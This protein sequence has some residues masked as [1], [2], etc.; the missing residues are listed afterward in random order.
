MD[1]VSSRWEKYTE[2]GGGKRVDILGALMD[3]KDP[4]TGE[5]MQFPELA[6][7]ASTNV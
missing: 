7:N 5:K 3:A 6:T 4:Q 2:E 1:I